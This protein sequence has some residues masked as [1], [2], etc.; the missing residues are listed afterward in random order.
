MR[1]AC[2]IDLFIATTQVSSGMLRLFR[3][4][5]LTVEVLLASACIPSLHRAID[6]D[7]DIY[8]D[9]A[10]TANPPVYPLVQQCVS[11]DLVMILL[12]PSQ[13]PDAP[14][15]AVEIRRRL[16]EISFSSAF[17]SEL[18][19]VALAKREAERSPFPF[20]RLQHRLRH[21]K[22][23]A[24][25]S[26]EFMGRLNALS[27][28][29]AHPLFLRALRDEGRRRAGSWLGENYHLIGERSSFSLERHL[30]WRPGTRSRATPPPAL[31]ARA[32]N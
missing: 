2:E 30:H 3:T 1:A 5:Q 21:L 29:N 18:Q 4:R 32:V 12:Q 27:K 8:W 17:F 22:T 15:T 31:A 19:G 20:G 25:D 13:R 9:G 6:I 23:H 24:I 7:G 28:L 26:P 10:L 16:N 14:A 11:R